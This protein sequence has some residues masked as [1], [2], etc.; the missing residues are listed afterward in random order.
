MPL[1]SF[2]AQIVQQRNILRRLGW[3]NGLEI[4]VNVRE[5]PV[6]HHLLG[7]GRHLPRRTPHI[8]DHALRAQRWRTTARPRN[9]ALPDRA[10]ALIAA[11]LHVNTLAGFGITRGVLRA[12]QPC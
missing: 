5:L 4:S 11:V 9:R 7:E 2:S 6:R 10:M 12:A 3:R 8:A 1:A